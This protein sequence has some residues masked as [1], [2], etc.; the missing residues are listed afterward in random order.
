MLPTNVTVQVTP[1]TLALVTV[2]LDANEVVMAARRFEIKER[3]AIVAAIMTDL[4]D[5]T[6]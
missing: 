2:N 4:A 3:L 5:E 6:G 1:H